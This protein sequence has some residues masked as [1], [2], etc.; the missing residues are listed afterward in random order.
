[1]LRSA[2]GLTLTLAVLTSVQ[3][4]AP[5]APITVSAA[6]SL[7]D[8]L[9]QIVKAYAASGGGPVRLNLAASNVLA[10]QIVNGAPADVFIS[11]DEAQ[12][13]VV[14]RA[15]RVVAGTRRDLLR[16]QLAV[17]ASP[18]RA[19]YVRGHFTAA[20]PDLRRIAIGDPAAVPAGV[21]ARQYL[22][23]AGLWNAYESRIVPTANVRAALSAVENGSADAAIVYLS[24][25]TITTRATVAFVVPA[26]QGPRIVYPAAV[27]T[28]SSDPDAAK[29]FV[30][31]LSGPEASALFERH[32]FL[33]AAGR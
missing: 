23:A 22:E 17:V 6:I 3:D 19:A 12:M 13:D 30:A 1:M 8:A 28:S 20:P 33:P 9:E 29:R 31:F 10:R 5:R 26:A 27:L 16:N 18:D 2:L 32:K 11:A 25:T 7:T 15:N 14:Q 21:Y 24:D 4:G